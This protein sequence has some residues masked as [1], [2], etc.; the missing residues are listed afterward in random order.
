[1]RC[2][3]SSDTSPVNS[4]SRESVFYDCVHPDDREYVASKVA[5]AVATRSRLEIEGRIVQKNGSIRLVQA[6]AEGF[7]DET[8]LPA[9]MLGSTRDV[10]EQRRAE[11]A[12]R[13]SEK[14]FRD[15]FENATDLVCTMDEEGRFITLN[16]SGEA[17]TG[18]TRSEAISKSLIDIASPESKD[19]AI[20]FCERAL[21]NDRTRH[22]GIDILTKDERTVSIEIERTP[23]GK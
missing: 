11:T 2:S 1:M 15:L 16:R 22:V 17:I 12:L 13:E 7:Y 10:T 5:E 23:A 4:R 18:L 14:Q 9:R 8:G 20:E 3:A 19:L 21:H 6:E